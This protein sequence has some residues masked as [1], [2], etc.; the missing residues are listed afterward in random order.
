MEYF[1]GARAPAEA[2]PLVAALKRLGISGRD[3]AYLASADPDAGDA[4]L[5]KNYR[6]E[7]RYMVSAQQ[8]AEAAR[9]I[10]LSSW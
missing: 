3:A 4:E 8:R 10:G 2:L 6:R 9:L 1:E 5:R 7:F